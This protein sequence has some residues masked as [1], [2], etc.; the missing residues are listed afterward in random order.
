MKTGRGSVSS[1]SLW[2]K[3]AVANSPSRSQTHD[4]APMPSRTPAEIIHHTSDCITQVQPALPPY[5][6]KLRR[7]PWGCFRLAS[8]GPLGLPWPSLPKSWRYSVYP[9][10]TPR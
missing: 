2:S 3:D 5:I 4:E 1:Q 10:L 7:P 9:T 8:L 6:L